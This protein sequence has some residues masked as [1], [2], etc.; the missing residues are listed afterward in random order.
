VHVTVIDVP[1][2]LGDFRIAAAGE[3]G[4]APSKRGSATRTI[5]LQIGVRAP[6]GAHDP[7]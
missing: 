6:P 1:A 3:L 2:F 5:P 7:S 4:H